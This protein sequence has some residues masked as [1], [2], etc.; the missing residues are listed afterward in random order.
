MDGARD[1]GHSEGAG[2]S[3]TRRLFR[4]AQRHECGCAG[5]G[6]DRDRC[7]A[8]VDDDRRRPRQRG[9]YGHSRSTVPTRRSR[10][11]SRWP[12]ETT[13]SQ[14]NGG[15]CMIPGFD[16]GNSPREYTREAIEGKTILFTTTNGTVGAGRRAGGAR[17][18]RRLVRELHPGR[19]DGAR[20]PPA[21]R[22]TLPS[23][24]PA[25]NGTSRSRMRSAPGASCASSAAD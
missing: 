3:A 6:G 18:A 15:T 9:A 20:R 12:A 2:L 14:G 24:P 25:L 8:R 13:S 23:S 10:A 1:R 4:R 17:S 16:L 22:S 7:A 5:A 21:R 11:P 19:R